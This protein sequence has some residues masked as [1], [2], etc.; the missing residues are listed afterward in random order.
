MNEIF[1]RKLLKQNQMRALARYCE[2]NFLYH[3]IANRIVENVQ[4]FSRDFKNCLEI[5]ARDGYLTSL[6]AQEQNI[7]NTSQILDDE[8]LL[9]LQEDFDLV[10]SNLNFH[11]INAVPQFLLQIKNLLKPGGM[12]IASF[13]AEENLPELHKT[14]FEVE[15]EIY[16]GISPRMIPTI[17]V[18]TAA[19]LLQKAGFSHPISNLERIEIEYQDPYNLLKDLKMMGQGNIMHK[20]SRRFF[21]K[22]FLQ[23]VLQYYRQN[24][25]NQN[26]SVKATFEIVTIVGFKKIT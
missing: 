3:E 21:T 26:G 2:H 12:F 4:S 19:N 7:K 11:H 6:L 8:I 17:D 15:S 13:F 1:D 20:R 5:G 9:C 10:V 24:F 18:K 16:N 23:K 22:S 14:I 25:S